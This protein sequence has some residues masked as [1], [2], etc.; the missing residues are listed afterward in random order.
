V[1][2][3]TFVGGDGVGAEFE[4]GFDV[5]DCGLASGGVE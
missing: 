3:G 5:V 2:D 1:D 4:R